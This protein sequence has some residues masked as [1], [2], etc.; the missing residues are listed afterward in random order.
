MD[1]NEVVGRLRT[2]GR[3]DAL[4]GMARCG[5][6]TKHAFGVSMPCL[7][8]MAREIGRNHALA[9]DLGARAFTTRAFWQAS[10]MI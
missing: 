6:A 8:H 2:L 10:P 3:P 9:G 5:I 7:R 1:A 4:A